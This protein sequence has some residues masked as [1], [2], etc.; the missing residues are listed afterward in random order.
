MHNDALTTL[1]RKR[2]KLIAECKSVELAIAAI[3]DRQ[4]RRSRERAMTRAVTSSR[5]FRDGTPRD[6]PAHHEI[7]RRY[8]WHGCQSGNTLPSRI[9]PGRTGS[10]KLITLIRL[11]E[12]ERIFSWR[13]GAI[14]PDNYSGR[15]GLIL[16]AHHI[17]HSGP[18]AELHI[19]AWVRLWAPWMS[20]DQ[21][22][23]LAER[24]IAKP[25]KF[26]ADTL[27]RRLQLSS[28]ERQRL[29]ITTIGAFDQDAEARKAARKSRR[30][31]A[32]RLRRR[33]KGAKPRDQY[34]PLTKTKPWERLG[35][36]R[37]S[38]YRHGR[39]MPTK[40]SANIS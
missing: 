25:M 36:T 11:R 18:H 5:V 8:A 26:K 16:A 37:R 2:S 34:E 23:T 9:Q 27:G 14:L 28:I 33:A 35:M 31:T 7:A 3:E 15:D 17:A 1:K 20:A 12:L 38:W 39:P 22:A 29:G 32:E 6:T 30:R 10:S 24:V 13:Y 21:V 4:T 40:A 19:R